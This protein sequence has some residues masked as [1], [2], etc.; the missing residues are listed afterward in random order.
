[1]RGRSGAKDGPEWY[2]LGVFTSSRDGRWSV[3]HRG[4]LSWRGRDAN[5]R[6]IAAIIGASAGRSADGIG[7]LV[8]A[9]PRAD[10]VKA[11]ETQH[12]ATELRKEIARIAAAQR[13]QRQ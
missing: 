8:T 7:V 9:T 13:H 10:G 12:Q 6:S 2:S 3:H 1:M 4:E 5:G 11:A